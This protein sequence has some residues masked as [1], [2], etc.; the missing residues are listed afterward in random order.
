MSGTGA[1]AQP[2]TKRDVKAYCGS[3]MRALRRLAVPRPLSP[4]ATLCRSIL[5]YHVPWLIREYPG[6]ARCALAVLSRV[7][8]REAVERWVSGARP[9]PVWAA[10][11]LRAVTEARVKAGQALLDWI[12]RYLVERE[13]TE[14]RLLAEARSGARFRRKAVNPPL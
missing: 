14:A 6:P 5:G 11:D 2:V 9:L 13:A 1:Q 10:R 7:V 3:H 8:T 4:T 12:D